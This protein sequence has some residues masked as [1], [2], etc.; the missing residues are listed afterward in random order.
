MFKKNGDILLTLK[1]YNSRCILAWLSEVVYEASLNPAYSATDERFDLIAAA[2][3][4]GWIGWMVCI[5]KAFEPNNSERACAFVLD[6]RHWIYTLY[7]IRPMSTLDE[8]EP[9]LT[10]FSLVFSMN[11][12]QCCSTFLRWVLPGNFAL[13]KCMARF[14]VY[15]ETAGRY[16]HLGCST[17]KE[18]GA[19]CTCRRARYEIWD[20]ALKSK[21]P[22]VFDWSHEHLQRGKTISG[23]ASRA[24]KTE[25]EA[26]GPSLVSMTGWACSHLHET[27]LS[28]TLQTATCHKDSCSAFCSDG[29]LAKILFLHLNVWTGWACKNGF[30]VRSTT[31]HG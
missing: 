25:C 9:A 5:P 8:S 28:S 24:H 4:H 10:W 26:W 3:I 19:G 29:M 31:M 16:L 6:F 13:R 11:I 15:I 21:F 23:C 1:A 27:F 7:Y 12:F 17:G 14:L 2:L 30:F 20:L 22:E 18:V